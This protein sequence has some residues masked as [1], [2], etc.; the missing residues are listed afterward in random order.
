MAEARDAAGLAPLTSGPVT[1]QPGAVTLTTPSTLTG[2][3]GEATVVGSR[4]PAATVLARPVATGP[5][6]VAQR[7]QPGGLPL[8]WLAAGA[9]A[10]LVVG[11]LGLWALLRGRTAPPS[12][13]VAPSA[14]VSPTTSPGGNL[15]VGAGTLVID[16]LPWGEVVAV[17]DAQGARRELGGAPFTPLAL[18]LPAGEYTVEVRHPAFPGQ[19]SARVTVRSGGTERCQVEF[20]RLDAAEYFRKSG[21]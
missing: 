15:A 11:G 2:S 9:L 16:A 21:L 19:Q 20:Q 12:P 17:K 14:A 13:G 18:S 8:G 4:P 1:P 3:G 6:R 5:T 10:L 7:P